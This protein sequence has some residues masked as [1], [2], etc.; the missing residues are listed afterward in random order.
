MQL[1]CNEYDSVEEAFQIC[2]CKVQ[3]LAGSLA[4]TGA[5]TW[6]WKPFDSS[7]H[8]ELFTQWHSTTTQNTSLFTPKTNSKKLTYKIWLANKY[9]VDI[10]VIK[11]FYINQTVCFCSHL[12]LFFFYLLFY[13]PDVLSHSTMQE[14][15][16]AKMTQPR[17]GS[18]QSWMICQSYVNQH[19]PQYIIQGTSYIVV[20]SWS[21]W[22]YL[23]NTK[24]RSLPFRPYGWNTLR[25]VR[26]ESMMWRL[27]NSSLITPSPPLKWPEPPEFGRRLKWR[28]ITG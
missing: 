15:I 9:L 20:Q 22:L 18:K 5:W 10:V 17:S 13:N 8:Q 24:I 16:S 14:I 21:Q 27:N 6:I 28:R 19:T 2:M 23:L 11:T 4:V 12:L 7:K 25:S 26:T 1:T 3:F